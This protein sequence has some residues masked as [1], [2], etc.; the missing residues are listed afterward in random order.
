[1][2]WLGFSWQDEGEDNLYYASDYFDWMVACAEYLIA[3]GNAYV[4]S[5]SAD[6]MRANRGT[7]TQAGVDSPFRERSIEENMNLFKR[8]QAGEFPDGADIPVSYTHLDV[9]KIQVFGD[10]HVH[11]GQG[12]DA[13]EILAE[14][15]VELVEVRFVLDQRGAREDV[16]VIQAVFDHVLLQG[17]QQHQKLLGRHRELA[18]LQ[19]QE[20]VDQHLQLAALAVLARHE[21]QPFK[22]MNILLV[23]EQ[24]AVQR[25]DGGF[26]ILA[27]QGF[28][29]DVFG[30]QKLQPVEQFGG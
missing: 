21:D 3:S 17:L 11:A 7:L 15:P 20:E 1:M 10:Q 19:M 13:L 29:R 16:E 12:F 18:R 4:D 24:G 25:R 9:D 14:R 28:G 8:M 22:E 26:L 30:Q 27:A 2:R 5:H 23:L 6:E